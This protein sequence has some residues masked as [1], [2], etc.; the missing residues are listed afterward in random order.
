MYTSKIV[1]PNGSQPDT[2][3]L[4]VAPIYELEQSELSVELADLHISGAKTINVGGAREAMIVTVPFRMLV[5]FKNLHARL[6]RELEKKFT[7]KHVII[8][9]ERR[10]LPKESRNNRAKRQKRPMSRTLT[11]VHDA[12]LEDMLFPTEIVGRRTRVRTDGSKLLKIFLDPKDQANADKLDTFNVVY[13]TL[14][15]RDASFE[16][17][18]VNKE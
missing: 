5:G 9:G 6:V 1:K 10:I 7:G 14:T 12:Y 11:A 13:K 17:Q 3:E 16:F 18:A 8:I 2:L 4:E 15:G